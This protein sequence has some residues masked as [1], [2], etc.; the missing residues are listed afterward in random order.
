MRY[1]CCIMNIPGIQE[2]ERRRNEPHP[3][4]PRRGGIKKGKELT[5]RMHIFTPKSPEGDFSDRGSV[6]RKLLAPVLKKNDKAARLFILTVSFV[7]FTAI[8]ILSRVK[9]DV[10]LGFDVHV[11]ALVNAIINSTVSVLLISAY[12]AVKR[13]N[14]VLHKRLMYAAIILSI[15]FLVSYIAHHLLAG[16]TRFGGEGAIRYIYYFI[17]VTHIFLAAIVL[18]FILFTA[19]RGLTSE[20]GRHK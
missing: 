1:G 15:C 20:F 17:L 18:P 12:V 13:R 6:N 3:H 16:D 5:G 11:F 14:Y 4:P 8:V 9:L 2:R 10:N 7:I 19:Y